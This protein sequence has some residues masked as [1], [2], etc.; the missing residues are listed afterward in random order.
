MKKT[1]IKLLSRISKCPKKLLSYL[2]NRSPSGTCLPPS[3]FHICDGMANPL[4]V[5]E[6]QSP[7]FCLMSVATSTASAV[8]STGR[9]SDEETLL[10]LLADDP[11]LT[12]GA[13]SL[14][15]PPCVMEKLVIRQ[16]PNCIVTEVLLSSYFIHFDING[17][18]HEEHQ[19]VTSPD[20]EY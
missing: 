20:T 7:L 11:F 10:P 8:V 6:E 3:R 13:P 2:G 5:R 12:L 14:C 1:K 4:R 16:S 17:E 18:F 15:V 19:H 9:P